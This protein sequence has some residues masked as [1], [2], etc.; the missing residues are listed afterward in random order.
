MEIQQTGELKTNIKWSHYYSYAR[1]I[2]IL[3]IR[4]KINQTG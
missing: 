3:D 2:C 4:Y 1:L